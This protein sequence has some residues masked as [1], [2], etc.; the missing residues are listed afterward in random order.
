MS[1][2]GLFGIKIQG[3]WWQTCIRFFTT[4]AS[5]FYPQDEGRPSGKLRLLYECAPLA[6]IAEQARAVPPPEKTRHGDMPEKY[7]P[8]H[9]I[10]HR[11]SA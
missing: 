2:A 8:A 11:Q 5:N 10:R 4:V 1:R 9:S 6:M 7:S 3:H